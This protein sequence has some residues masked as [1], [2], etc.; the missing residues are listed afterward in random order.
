MVSAAYAALVLP[1]GDAATLCNA[2]VVFTLIFGRF[3]S[4][5]PISYCKGFCTVLLI[6]GLVLIVKPPM[7]FGENDNENGKLFEKFA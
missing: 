3:I 1:L 4:K 6:G 2:Q 7:I 5:T